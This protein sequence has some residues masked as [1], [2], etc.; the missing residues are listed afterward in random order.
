MHCTM[1]AATNGSL[2]ELCVN[3]VSVPVLWGL[4]LPAACLNV[5]KLKLSYNK[6]VTANCITMAC[7]SYL[8]LTDVQ[9]RGLFTVVTGFMKWSSIED[10]ASFC[11]VLVSSCPQLVKLSLVTL[12]L[13]NNKACDILQGLMD[14]EHLNIIT[15][16][17][18]CHVKLHVSRRI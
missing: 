6:D 17:Q 9:V 3:D 8:H 10:S 16:V 15:Y 1:Q 4:G 5:Q 14:H 7:S 13:G 18:Q 2:E 11:K 12:D